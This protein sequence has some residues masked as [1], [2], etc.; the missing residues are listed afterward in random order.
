MLIGQGVPGA[1]TE[2]GVLDLASLASVRRFA[3]VFGE[4]VFRPEAASPLN[5]RRGY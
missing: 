2:V 1:S 4:R 5:T 3:A